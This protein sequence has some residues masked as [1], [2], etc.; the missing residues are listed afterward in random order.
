MAGRFTIGRTIVL[1]HHQRAARISIRRIGNGIHFSWGS[2]NG[3]RLES[4]CIWVRDS[5][6]HTVARRTCIIPRCLI[7]LGKYDLGG[8]VDR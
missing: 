8:D 4:D 5:R 2:G 7:V 3:S 6:R 1:M